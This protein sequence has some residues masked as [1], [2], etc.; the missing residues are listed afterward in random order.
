TRRAGRAGARPGCRDR[1]ERPAV[2]GG[3]Q[4]DAPRAPPAAAPCRSGKR[5]RRAAR[6]LF[7]VGGLPRGREGVH[8]EAQAGLARPLAVRAQ[9]GTPCG[10]AQ[11]HA[12]EVELSALGE[13]ALLS[14]PC[15]GL[16]RT[17][18]LV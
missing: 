12:G 8:G 4:A 11:L 18:V 14:S 9:L 7:R 13:L 2:A 15:T 3:Q 1:L 17:D 16:V 10:E 6:V 5:A